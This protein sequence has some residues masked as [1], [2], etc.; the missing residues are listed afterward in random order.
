MTVAEEIMIEEEEV[1]MVG[2]LVLVRVGVVAWDP[3]VEG[4][5]GTIVHKDQ[6]IQDGHEGLPR[7]VIRRLARRDRV[8][9]RV[10]EFMV[11]SLRTF[12]LL[13]YST[14]FQIVAITA[15]ICNSSPM[16]RKSKLAMQ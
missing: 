2:I 6:W 11:Y 15:R 4:V 10:Y 14:L 16:F 9:E 8:G 5:M 3:V 13:N 12:E 1:T 7:I